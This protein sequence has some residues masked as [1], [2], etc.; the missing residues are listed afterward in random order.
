[1]P[2]MTS[3]I[4]KLQDFTVT[5]KPRCFENETSFPQTKKIIITHQGLIHGKKRVLWRIRNI[6]KYRQFE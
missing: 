1:M 6:G 4:F 2:M 3:Q 5:Q